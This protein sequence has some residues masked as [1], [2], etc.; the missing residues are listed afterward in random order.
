[1]LIYT[2]SPS[3]SQK[4]RWWRRV[5]TQL[6]S[7]WPVQLICWRHCH[8]PLGFT[9]RWCRLMLLALCVVYSGY[10]WRVEPMTRLVKA[11]SF[12]NIFLNYTMFKFI[13]EPHSSLSSIGCPS[14]KRVSLEQH[15]SWCTLGFI[16]SIALMPQ[17]CSTLSSSAWINVL[18]R[19]V[20]G[21]QS[22]TAVTLQRQVPALHLGLINTYY[23]F[24]LDLPRRWEIFLSHYYIIVILK[25]S[26]VPHLNP[27]FLIPWQI[28]ALRLLQAVLPSWDKTERSQDMKFLVEKLFGFLGSL[29]STCS[30]DLPLLRGTIHL[31][32]L[33]R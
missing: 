20:E 19:I 5:F 31:L 21:H 33:V 28:L 3:L 27:S 17:M 2:T 22:F 15:R 10:W 26:R 14:H 1:M 8:Y 32:T 23:G 13:F 16:R 9:L 11:Q 4:G 12:C 30:S 6:Q 24:W 29:L 18:I 25:P 7:C